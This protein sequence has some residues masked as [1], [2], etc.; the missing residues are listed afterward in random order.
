M[1]IH[2]G[3]GSTITQTVNLI[4][5]WSRLAGGGPPSP[6]FSD[7]FNRSNGA[8][9]NGWFSSPDNGAAQPV[10]Q[11]GALT[12][13]DPGGLVGLYRSVDLSGGLTVTATA[14][15]LNGFGGLPLRY[16][17]Y[18]LLGGNGSTASGYGLL[19]TRG[20]ANYSDSAVRLIR[21]GVELDLVHPNFQFGASVTVTFGLGSDGSITGLVTDGSNRFDFNFAAHD[22]AFQ[23]SNLTL[24]LGSPDARSGAFIEPTFDD[25]SIAPGVSIVLPD[26]FGNDTSTHGVLAIGGTVHGSIET[27]DDKDWFAVS[28]VVGST[29]QFDLIGADGD[30]G[31]LANPFMRVRDASG[32]S[33]VFNEDAGPSTHDSRI[34]FTALTTGTYFVSVGG[35]LVTGGSY[36]LKAA[37]PDLGPSFFTGDDEPNVLGGGGGNDTLD[38]RGGSDTLFG[39]GGNDSLLG[40]AGN[41]SILA[42]AGNDT[43]FGGGGLDWLQG[44]EGN[45]LLVGSS[46]ATYMYGG[47]GN[48]TLLGG[49]GQDYLSGGVGDDSVNGGDYFDIIYG[50]E[51]NDFI[52]GGLGR[53]E[54]NYSSATAGVTVSLNISGPQDTGAAGID[55][56][57]G[58]EDLTGSDFDD[59]LVGNDGFNGLVGGSGNDTLNGLGGFDDLKGGVGNDSLTG[60][61]DN[62]ILSGNTGNDTLSG[63]NGND[64]LNSGG[65]D[66]ICDGGAGNDFIQGGI[67]HLLLGPEPV[68]HATLIGG[69]GDDSIQSGANSDDVLIGGAGA[70]IYLVGGGGNCTI[71]ADR[72]GDAIVFN[73]VYTPTLQDVGDNLVVTFENPNN[74]PGAIPE[75]WT[76]V[77]L[78][79]ADV[80]LAS[81][82]ITI[83]APAP[84]G[85]T[86]TGGSGDD[87]LSGAS[88]ADRLDG[89]G[90]NDTLIGLSGG[91]TLVGGDGSDL[92]EGGTGN[93]SMDGG[94]G[95]DSVDYFDATGALTVNLTLTGA[96][97]TGGSGTDTLLNIE[98]VYGGSFSDT[99][100]GDG[101]NNLLWGRGGP[102]VLLGGGGTDFLDG[103]AGDDLIDGGPGNDYAQYGDSPSGVTVSLAVSGPQNTGGAGIDTLVSI[104]YLQGS[105]F[106]D[107]FTGNAADNF[108]SG[109]LGNDSLVGADGSD[110]LSGDA[111][112][113]S[114]NGGD[115]NDQLFGAGGND[116]LSGGVGNDVLDGGPGN[117]VLDGG[118]GL[119]RLQYGSES[120][121]VV[122]S[123]AISGPQNTGGSGID[124]L[125]GFERLTGTN[126][127]DTLTGDAADNYLYGRGGNDIIDGGAGMD[128]AQYDEA[129]SAV[130]VNLSIIAPQNTGG[131]GVDQLI[132]IENLIG[133]AFGDTL[134]GDSGSNVL[135]G[136]DGSDSLSGGDGGD[137]LSGSTG[138]DTNDGGAGNDALDGADG[139]DSLAGG[140]GN[141]TLNGGVGNDSLDG[142]AGNDVL[143]DYDGNN[144][145][146]GGIGDDQIVT[147]VG[148]DTV[149]GGSG[150]D[151]IFTLAGNDVVD[152]GSGNDQINFSG[153]SHSAPVTVNLSTVGPQSLG[154]GQGLVTITGVEGITG[155][156][157]YGDTL[158]GDA[159]ANLISGLGGDDL[160][161]GGAGNDV[162]GGDDGND[163]ASGG[164]GDDNLSGGVGSDNLSG[165]DGNDTLDAGVGN[166][167]LAGGRGSDLFIFQAGFGHDTAIDFHNIEDD[168][169]FVGSGF[170]S[171]ADMKAHA[172]QVG[173]N[174]LITTLS[175]DTLQLN[176]I[177]VASLQSGDFLFG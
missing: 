145:L 122:V 157:S 92:L 162:I 80:T 149:Y 35:D 171:F 94:A 65:G 64:Q 72:D 141:D 43:V 25:V 36:T 7:D 85:A 78:H 165:G 135:E 33:L 108:M 100:T 53:D 101:G 173:A 24:V 20:D 8:V 26:D 99:L 114:L 120:S 161:S 76:I 22:T 124:T 106:D 37:Q 28:L 62:D 176:N 44:D 89:A 152:G 5:E 79:S 60:D 154:G 31:T 170:A 150:N 132:R 103:G 27:P 129:P 97:T 13:A 164:T 107:S 21:N 156:N 128:S 66:D 1:E 91:D 166:D 140:D 23:G 90:G 86:L 54:I 67:E 55:S 46:F 109:G 61:D 10:I 84:G 51:G 3:N 30:G 111:G 6:T 74:L 133:S 59:K 130:A 58:V 93:D 127:N 117:D 155:T 75:K 48:D 50:S 9:G 113:D 45:D 177:T 169:R 70:D 11:G 49:D 159:G 136:R 82:R 73:T 139:A 104:E 118:P 87:S 144:S 119:D 14:T 151:I 56:I 52:D 17:S 32:S 121:G 175:G 42:G 148:N 41:D 134:I 16:E 123:L 112:N 143:V 163:T 34:T 116:S 105:S 147:G 69:A 29:Y 102:D 38:G 83:N 81:G 115:G 77:G 2:P 153:F 96:Q 138:N 168:I 146:S 125:I 88:G 131:A 172:V 158:T 160:L 68:G 18:I 126:F 57:K 174:V 39:L 47:D 142:G 137:T 4:D 167:V 98:N 15:Q 63:G 71:Y 19:L 12:R 95:L 110:I 40:G